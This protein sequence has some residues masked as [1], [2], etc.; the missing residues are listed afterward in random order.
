MRR[1]R[2]GRILLK[3]FVFVLGAAFVGLGLA[4]AVLPGPLTIPPV[5]VG[6][7]LW[8]TE[9]AWAERLRDR[10]M[11]AAQSAWEAARRRPVRSAVATLAGLALAGVAI[12]A[13]GQ[14]NV[15]AQVQDLLG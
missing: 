5:L 8:S 9:F 14:V 11:A 13:A 10:A 3:S 15:L 12:Y 6:V 2:V 7:Y 1:T 4:L